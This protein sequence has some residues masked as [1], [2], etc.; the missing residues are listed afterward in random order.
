MRFGVNYFKMKRIILTLSNV[1]CFTFLLSAQNQTFEILTKSYQDLAQVYAE[2]ALPFQTF[3]IN[4]NRDTT[5]IGEQGTRIFIPKAA[6]EGVLPNTVIDFKLK[7]AYR[8]SDMMRENLSTNS[9]LGLLQTGGM[10]YSEASYKGTSIQ[11][12]KNLKVTFPKDGTDRSNMQMFAGEP[13]FENNNQIVWKPMSEATN[14]AN[15]DELTVF[16]NG[17]YNPYMLMDNKGMMTFQQIIDTTGC[18]PLLTKEQVMRASKG[19][20]PRKS[21]SN[22]GLAMSIFNFYNP[23]K[24]KMTTLEHHK[25]TFQEVYDFYKVDNFNA[26]TKQKGSSWDSLMRVRLS[27]IKKKLTPQF[28]WMMSRDSL[29][30]LEETGKINAKEYQSAKEILEKK[31]TKERDSLQ[32]IARQGAINM[33]IKIKIDSTQIDLPMLGWSNIDCF[34]SLPSN[35]LVKIETNVSK[36]AHENVLFLLP[37]DRIFASNTSEQKTDTYTFPKIPKNKKAMIVA[38]KVENGQSYLAVKQFITQNTKIELEFIPLSAAEIKEKL[39]DLDK[40]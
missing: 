25:R 3:K 13:D 24:V 16:F 31:I 5:I 34:S 2:I 39:K 9:N 23:T 14:N 30:K 7:E 6:F 33:N 35:N 32:A 15:K 40:L 8:F 26:L 12:R 4:V 38:I 10:F 18:T 22:A 27:F 29:Q 37:K 17:K 11:L 20:I 1:V 28:R 19:Y 21:M 36:N